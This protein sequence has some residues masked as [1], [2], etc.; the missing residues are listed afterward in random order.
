MMA[1]LCKR[2]DSALGWNHAGQ[3]GPK[4]QAASEKQANIECNNIFFRGMEGQGLES[5]HLC[6]PGKSCST[7]TVI[8]PL[9]IC[10]KSIA[11]HR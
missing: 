2:I 3:G 4:G 10:H 7:R 1:V 5:I 11:R 9:R 6:L 8:K